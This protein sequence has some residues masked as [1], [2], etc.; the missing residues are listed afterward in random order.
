[1]NAAPFAARATDDR[2]TR[3]ATWSLIGSSVLFAVMALAAKQA[4]ARLPGPQVA[5]VRF[6][7]G[8]L[9]VL[10]AG[11]LAGVDLRPRHRGWLLV[12]GV[13]GGAAVLCFFTCIARAGVG[14]ATLLNY[15]APVWSLAFSWRLLGERPQRHVVPA[16]ALTLV[17]VA[18][19]VGDRAR[20]G[21]GLPW[22][23]LGVLSAILSGLA[24]TAIRATRHARD[25]EAESAWTVFGAFTLVGTLA[26]APAT[27]PPLATFV[28]PTAAEWGWLALMALTSFGAQFIMVV[29]LQHVT[30]AGSGVIH[31]LTV[32][33][34]MLGGVV[35]FDERLTAHALLGSA[36][37][38]AGVAWV[39]LAGGRPA[40]ERVET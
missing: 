39:T 33:L 9:L 32:V 28:P 7:A 4:A 40:S 21:A 25:G 3:R 8:A 23:A 30:A 14:V 31:Q 34:A 10:G 11:L 27:F 2:A 15:T 19:V 38:I 37:T 17:G 16:L 5:F 24:V 35:F 6:A 20:P 1:M 36:L 18:L 22:I 13:A 12:R 29:A 26:T